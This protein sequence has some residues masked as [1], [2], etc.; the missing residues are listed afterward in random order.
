M[1]LQN[2]GT[3]PGSC[4]F[5]GVFLPPWMGMEGWVCG[6]VYGGW[7]SVWLAGGW[8]GCWVVVVWVVV[9]RQVLEGGWCYGSVRWVVG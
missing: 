9:G 8:L 5:L 7:A 6:R 2:L 3:V 4:V 1:S